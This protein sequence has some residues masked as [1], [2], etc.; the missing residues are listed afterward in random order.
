[1]LIAICMSGLLFDTSFAQVM[2]GGYVIKHYGPEQGYF[3]SEIRRMYRDSKGIIWIS[4][5]NGITR[6]DG[7][8]FINYDESDGLTSNNSSGFFEDP[9]G[10]I[11]AITG[12][13]DICRYNGLGQ[14]HF[15]KVFQINTG[16]TFMNCVSTRENEFYYVT[17]PNRKLIH[18]VGSRKIEITGIDGA[19]DFVARNGNTIY[20]WSTKGM[21]YVIEGDKIIDH[22]MVSTGYVDFARN[23]F[24]QSPS[25][26]TWL[27]AGKL[28]KLGIHGIM[29][30]LLLPAI[31]SQRQDLAGQFQLAFT[32][33]ND[34]Y[35][36]ST[37]SQ[38][39]YYDGRTINEI[40]GLHLDAQDS[41]YT[42]QC[43]CAGLFADRDGTVWRG[44]DMNGGFRQI[45]RAPFY[46]S[47]IDYWISSTDSSG[48]LI[49]S[50]DAQ[51]AKHPFM[52]SAI[53]KIGSEHLSAMYQD[54][55]DNIIY[56]LADGTAIQM[57]NSP[58][59]R[60]LYH[61]Q[62]AHPVMS[63]AQGRVDS[64]WLLGDKKI[65]YVSKDGSRELPIPVNKDDER[66]VCIDR[67]SRLWLTNAN[68]EIVT[69]TPAGEEHVMNKFPFSLKHVSSLTTDHTK[70]IWVAG[71]G[72]MLYAITPAPGQ[73]FSHCN[74]FKLAFGHLPYSIQNIQ[75]DKHKNLWI[76]Y[77][78]RIY[79]LLYG[80]DGS[81]DPGRYIGLTP[82]DGIAEFMRGA[83]D[84]ITSYRSRRNGFNFRP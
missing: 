52:R 8:T 10:H 77:P 28:F 18:A 21:I 51:Y 67:Y 32:G 54:N 16:N 3:G 45:K 1:M 55:A 70:N 60:Y 84:K 71:S 61:S 50:Y 43:L 56:S 49:Y 17:W 62:T 7:T 46:Y 68:I 58:D 12:T 4:N 81:Y 66:N 72:D 82:D 34:N 64:Y 11:Y 14:P 73:G 48:S 36:T 31:R 27:A 30:S 25:G 15:R 19:P 29:D 42:G 57:K 24:V 47:N 53:K 39:W 75:F 63:S 65:I 83:I 6:F 41:V 5:E 76:S 37:G 79:I 80:K 26:S 33:V 38:L 13:N 22:Y 35:Y 59:Y 23:P 78:D 44:N 20:T 74:F 40:P 69:Y 2:R 9:T